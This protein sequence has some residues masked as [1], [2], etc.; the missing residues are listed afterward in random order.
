M[1]L[2]IYMKWK[3]DFVLDTTLNY[4]AKKYIC[5]NLKAT[6]SA[7]L[8]TRVFI[9]KAITLLIYILDIE[10]S[11]HVHNNNNYIPT[12]NNVSPT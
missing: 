5:H 10:R 2:Y 4:S 11:Q 6:L 1:A 8:S 7:T 3:F 9:F 12:R